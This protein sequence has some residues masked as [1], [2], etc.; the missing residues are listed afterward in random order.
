MDQEQIDAAKE[1][2]RKYNE[3][4]NAAVEASAMQGEDGIS[5]LDL[6]DVGESIGFIEIPKIDVY[7]PI[8]SGTGEDVLQKGVGHLAESSYPIGGTS[9][10]SV[11]TGHR[12]LPSAVLF[13]DLDKM[14][15]GDVFYLHVLDEVLAY[16][17]DQI[18]VVLPEETQDIGIV[19][20]KDYCT[21][22]TCT[23]YAI[24]THRLLVRGERTEYIPP[25]ELA[26][27][28]AVHE[29]QSQTITKRIVDV[30]PWL[31]VSLL[32]VAG[33][34]GSIF[35][36]IVK[37]QRSYGE[38]QK[39][40]SVMQQNKAQKVI[41]EVKKAFIGKTECVE[42]LM[43]AILA[44]G[45]VLVEDVPGVG[46][47][48]LALAFAKAMNV[49]QNR[50]QF[51]PDVLPA[52]ITGFTV[53]NREKDGFFYRPGAVMCNILLAD[54][55]NRTSPKTQAALLEVMEEGSVTV[56]GV[57]RPVPSPF[58]VIATQNPVGSAGTQ[59]LPQSQLDR[60]LICF[61]IG[62]PDAAEE[63]DILKSRRSGNGLEDVRPVISSQE[64]MEM[65]KE[66]EEVFVHDQVYDYIVRL[67]QATRNNDALE[68]GLSPRGSL[69][70]LKMAQAR[71]YRKGR[72]FVIPADVA[73]EF[74]DVAAHR[75]QPVSSSG[76]DRVRAAAVL[77]RILKETPAPAPE[78]G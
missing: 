76:M 11:L 35:L 65:K 47:T 66:V 44:G 51:T 1:A 32:I 64:L 50:V 60:F 8:Y 3:Q 69:A 70:L 55:I 77:E 9:T 22:V 73:A 13:T 16:K 15:E 27:Q 53:Y 45:H 20:G 37:R 62:Y 40:Q 10:H 43:T 68:L 72:S 29:V 26:E 33:V 54:E 48:T 7:L 19:E 49:A 28:N 57:T 67:A 39:E 59:L 78:K 4:L 74:Q 31:V 12:G 18:K 24:N 52:D 71:A 41:E 75:V 46:K 5:Y 14:E 23:P 30:W 2:V 38:R 42:K 61:G 25:E 63:M 36:L 6:V 21:L 56:D 58:L 34:E 17:V